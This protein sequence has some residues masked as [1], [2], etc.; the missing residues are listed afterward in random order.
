MPERVLVFTAAD[1]P[2]PLAAEVPPALVEAGTVFFIGRRGSRAVRALFGAVPEP[3]CPPAVVDAG[4]GVVDRLS[5]GLADGH[6]C[7]AN[8]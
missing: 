4:M 7:S 1:L 6:A 3:D 8:A 5:R 2:P